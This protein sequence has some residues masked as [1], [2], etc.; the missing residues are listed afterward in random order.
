MNDD[1]RSEHIR[2]LDLLIANT[3][4]R[5]RRARKSVTTYRT[6]LATLRAVRTM[7]L[8]PSRGRGTVPPYLDPGVSD[9][10]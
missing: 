5:L 10:D 7:V 1:E 8:D 2:E 3:D 9:E 6:R 4:D